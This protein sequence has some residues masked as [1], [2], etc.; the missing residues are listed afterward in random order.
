MS[1]SKISYLYKFIFRKGTFTTFT[2]YFN[3]NDRNGAHWGFKLIFQWR[4]F[5][6]IYFLLLKYAKIDIHL[7]LKTEGTCLQKAEEK[8]LFRIF[9]WSEPTVDYASF[10]SPSWWREEWSV[11]N[12]GFRRW[13]KNQLFR[14]PHR[15]L[16]WLHDCIFILDSSIV[17]YKLSKL[18]CHEV[19]A[20]TSDYLYTVIYYPDMMKIYVIKIIFLRK[21][22]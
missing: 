14:S 1:L 15:Y 18:N 20:L 8:C 7:D 9:T 12:H 17:R 11:I 19:R 2:T 4:H 21:V 3:I 22:I 5:I 16:S 6:C 10:L 13:N